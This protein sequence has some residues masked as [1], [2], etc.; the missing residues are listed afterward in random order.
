MFTS[1]VMSPDFNLGDLAILQRSVFHP[2]YN[3]ALAQ[4]TDTEKRRGSVTP[5][6]RRWPVQRLYRVRVIAPVTGEVL[7]SVA[8]Y[9]L[10]P[11]HGV[12]FRPA[13]SRAEPAQPAGPEA[14]R[15]CSERDG[16]AP[17]AHG[18]ERSGA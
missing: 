5:A 17:Q 3:G 14:S 4:I 9:Q 11:L 1:S 8:R 6:G 16:H 15:R 10:R 13:L 12:A 7:F 18:T 2:E